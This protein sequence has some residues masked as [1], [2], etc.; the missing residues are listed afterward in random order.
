MFP[1][2]DV[3]VLDDYVA[4]RIHGGDDDLTGFAKDRR[5][6]DCE[7]AAVMSPF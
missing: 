4:S 7:F 3:D 6:G 2:V 1:S 5:A